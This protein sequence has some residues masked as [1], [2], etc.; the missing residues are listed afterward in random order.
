MP[1]DSYR[2]RILMKLSALEVGD[3]G[4]LTY[5]TPTCWRKSR[6]SS[7]GSA[8]A[9]VAILIPGGL[10]CTVAR[11]LRVEDRTAAAPAAILANSLLPTFNFRSSICE[12][13]ARGAGLLYST[14]SSGAIHFLICIECQ[15]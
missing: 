4:R 7:V 12:T 11:P 2:S 15:L 6:S 3:A 8:R 13:S 14:C 5:S 9:D 10:G 1:A